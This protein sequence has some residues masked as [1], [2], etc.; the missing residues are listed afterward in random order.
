MPKVHFLRSGVEAEV[1]AGANLRQ[2][3]L[4]HKVQLYPGINRV[5]NCHGLASCG[6]C[7]VLL[8]EGTEKNAGPKTFLEK[9]RLGM[10]Y[11]AIGHGDELRLACQTKVMGDMEVMERPP[12]NFSGV[13]GPEAERA[14][15]RLRQGKF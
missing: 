5:A 14:K 12:A 10:S 13:Y 4:Q 11:F 2:V 9:L 8:K 7:R 1:P 15:S 6:S 3:A